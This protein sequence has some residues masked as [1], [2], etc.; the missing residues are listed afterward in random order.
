M[1]HI[2]LNT[3]Q[4]KIFN[5]AFQNCVD[6]IMLLEE[7]RFIDFNPAALTLLGANNAAQLLNTH[8][9][10]LSPEKQPDGRLS[11]EKAKEMIAKIMTI[12]FKKGIKRFIFD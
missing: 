2:D 3:A 12:Y 10:E 1:Q 8:P 7:G 4:T 5:R 9:A 6:A 11:A